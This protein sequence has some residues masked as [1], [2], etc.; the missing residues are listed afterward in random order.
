M[1]LWEG[2]IAADHDLLAASSAFWKRSFALQTGVVTIGRIT[3]PT[4]GR[5]HID[6]EH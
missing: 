5:K 1:E 2:Q 3:D 4:V 6:A